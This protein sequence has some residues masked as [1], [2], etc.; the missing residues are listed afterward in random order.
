[1]INYHALLEL[2]ARL[3]EVK[4]EIQDLACQEPLKCE[5]TELI[6]NVLTNCLEVKPLEEANA[7]QIQ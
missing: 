1:M 2:T 3:C 5:S 4:R 6:N 7:K